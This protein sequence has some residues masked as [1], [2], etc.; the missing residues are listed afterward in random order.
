MRYITIEHDFILVQ[1]A[2]MRILPV[3]LWN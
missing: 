3:N 2:D 1:F